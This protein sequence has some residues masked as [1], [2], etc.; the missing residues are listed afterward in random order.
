MFYRSIQPQHGSSCFLC[1]SYKKQQKPLWL[2]SGSP[3]TDSVI[4]VSAFS[5]ENS[6]QKRIPLQDKTNDQMISP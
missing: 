4:D 3:A 5:V 2:G 6:N 1:P